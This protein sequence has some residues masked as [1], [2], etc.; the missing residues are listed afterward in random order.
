MSDLLDES[1]VQ[2]QVSDLTPNK[3]YSFKITSANI[4]GQSE[5]SGILYQY[6]AAVPSSLQQPQLIDGTRTW[7]SIGIQM[8]MPGS[9]TTDILGYQL[10]INEANSNAIPEIMVYDGK[11]IPNVL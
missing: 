8:F 9:S 2:K 1:E 6:A 4:K 10:F 3:L 5:Q 7:T 11:A